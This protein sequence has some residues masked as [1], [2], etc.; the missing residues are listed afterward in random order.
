MELWNGLRELA[1]FAERAIGDWRF[2]SSKGR[3]ERHLVVRTS[4]IFDVDVHDLKGSERLCTE[5]VCIDFLAPFVRAGN[6]PLINAVFF[7]FA[8][9][10][11]GSPAQI[12][13]TATAFSSFLKDQ[14]KIF[15][16]GCQGGWAPRGSPDIIN[17]GISPCL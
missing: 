12:P 4:T 7:V 3:R 16:W 17:A 10:S 5:K 8:E 13:E 1:A 2:G 11:A 6:L 15:S 9:S 14:I